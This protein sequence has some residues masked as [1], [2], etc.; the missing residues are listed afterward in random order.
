MNAFH[1]RAFQGSGLDR[2]PA[3][4][5]GKPRI[6]RD[7]RCHLRWDHVDDIALQLFAEFRFHF[8]RSSIHPR[9]AAIIGSAAPLDNAGVEFFPRILK[10]WLLRKPILRI[11]RN[12]LAAWFGALQI[13][14]NHADPL[15][16]AGRAAE[17]IV[18]DHHHKPAAIG[19]G[20]K[21][22]AQQ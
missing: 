20:F 8:H 7:L 9:H 4:L 13:I 5:I 3:G 15:I 14:G 2:A 10:K 19:H 6:A 11:K 12:Q 18:G 21:L 16:R 1:L 17:G 22:A